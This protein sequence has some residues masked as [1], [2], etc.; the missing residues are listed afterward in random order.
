MQDIPE[1]YVNMIKLTHIA[2]IRIVY[3]NIYR[4]R[5]GIYI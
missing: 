1:K 4:R 3:I 2:F 5:I